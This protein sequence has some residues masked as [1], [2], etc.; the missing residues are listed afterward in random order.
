[1]RPFHSWCE[2]ERV[3]ASGCV[4]VLNQQFAT[5]WKQQCQVADREVALHGDQDVG[6]VCKAQGDGSSLSCAWTLKQTQKL[7]RAPSLA[8]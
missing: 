5:D 3:S 8:T 7:Q 1:M 2:C 6:L 4:M